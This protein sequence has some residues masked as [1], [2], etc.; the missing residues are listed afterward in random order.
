MSITIS[1]HPWYLETRTGLNIIRNDEKQIAIVEE[2]HD[3]S[4]VASAHMMFD[5][6]IDLHPLIEQVT[7][8][9]LKEL[10]L[11]KLSY[12]FEKVAAEIS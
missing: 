6:L 11:N 9:E 10:M 1:D 7:D 8:E 5:T 4:L 2:L 12:V 3:A